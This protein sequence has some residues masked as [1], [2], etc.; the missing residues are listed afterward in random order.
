MTIYLK[1]KQWG[2]QTCCPDEENTVGYFK[3]DNPDEIKFYSEPRFNS[4]EREKSLNRKHQQWKYENSDYYNLTLD[5]M[6][7]KFGNIY[8]IESSDILIGKSN[9]IWGWEEV[10]DK[11]NRITWIRID[12]EESIWAPL[13]EYDSDEDY[14]SEVEEILDNSNESKLKKR[15]LY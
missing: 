12:N 5:E 10:K 11:E 9:S 1:R 3:I 4:I 14:S 2:Y 13:D 15:K 7:K 8:D 6:T